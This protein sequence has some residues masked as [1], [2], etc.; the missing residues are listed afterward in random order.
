MHFYPPSFP[1]V[2]FFF[3]FFSFCSF[4][5]N[6]LHRLSDATLLF[7]FTL[8]WRTRRACVSLLL[9]QSINDLGRK[10]HRRSD[11]AR[12]RFWSLC[13]FQRTSAHERRGP[14]VVYY[15][16]K[17][18]IISRD[19]ICLFFFFFRNLLS[20]MRH[21][22]LSSVLSRIFACAHAAEASRYWCATDI[23]C[24]NFNGLQTC[25]QY[26]R[27]ICRY[28]ETRFRCEILMRSWYMPEHSDYF[29]IR[30]NYRI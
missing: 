21:E 22:P 23:I 4:Y 27:P 2:Y 3:P 28:I 15:F 19:A 1:R 24:T 29:L 14:V 10:R 8:K 6:G 13:C 11:Y 5:W 26:A 9:R 12:R 25:T 20:S 17:A 30:Y 18:I 7:A 16:R